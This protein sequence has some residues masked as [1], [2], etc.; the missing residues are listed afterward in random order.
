MYYNSGHIS[1]VCTQKPIDT[2]GAFRPLSISKIEGI[3][4]QLCAI[5]NSA[6]CFCRT[7]TCQ[8]SF[9]PCVYDTWLQLHIAH[10]RCNDNISLSLQSLRQQLGIRRA[11]WNLAVRFI[12]PNVLE[13]P[14]ARRIFF[15]WTAKPFDQV[16]GKIAR[17]VVSSSC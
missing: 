2:P 11:R 14:V 9:H 4:L 6:C 3:N 5:R 10:A 7:R 15:V 8:E 17:S 1:Y 16:E 13:S 12:V